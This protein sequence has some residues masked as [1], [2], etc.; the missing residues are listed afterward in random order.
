MQYQR[1]TIPATEVCCQG[2]G[3]HDTFVGLMAVISVIGMIML[4]T[5]LLALISCVLHAGMGDD[6][7]LHI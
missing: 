6:L 3:M 7:G 4:V 5:L 1:P 2:C